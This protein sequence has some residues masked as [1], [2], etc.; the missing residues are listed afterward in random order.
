MTDTVIAAETRTT[1]LVYRPLLRAMSQTG[2]AALASGLLSAIGIKMIAAVGGPAALATLSTLQ[3]LRQAAVVAATGNGQTALVQGASA[4]AGVERSEYVRTV[5]CWFAAAIS[6]VAGVMILWPRLVTALAGFGP[7]AIPMIPW[8]AVPVALT[9]WL[10]FSGALLTALGA[11]GRLAVLSVI[12]SAAMAFGA[13]P[14]AWAFAGG[15]RR[16]LVALLIFSSAV[17]AG[18]A[19]VVLA[20]FRERIE[21]WFRGPGRWWSGRAFRSFSMMSGAL[22]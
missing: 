5:A 18:A 8:L 4:L 20:S 7:G 1:Q 19:L 15:E 14:A 16:A 21:E 10:V 17:S 6:L 13:W 11:I 22:L 9:S 2:L 3:Q 12:A